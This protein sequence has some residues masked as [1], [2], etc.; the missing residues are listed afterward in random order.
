MAQAL[1]RRGN[2]VTILT[3]DALDQSQRY[4][5]SADEIMDGVRVVRVR[6]LSPWL[7]GQAN[8]STPLGMRKIAPELLKTVDIIHCHEFRTLENLLVTPFAASLNKPLILSPHGT[9][10]HETGR[11]TLK[12]LWDRLLSPTV[13]RRFSD[14]VGLSAIEVNEVRSLWSSFGA[15]ANFTV[16]PNGVDPQIFANLPGR[17][18]F[19]QRYRL[20]D[21]P[22]CLFMGRLHERKGI[23]LLVEAFKAAD[24]AEAKLVI[25]GPDEGMLATIQPLLDDRIIYTGYLSGSERLA[26]FAAADI[27][28][29][30][31]IGE[32]LPM[33]VLEAMAAGLPVIVS[34]GCNLPEVV[35]YGAGIEANAAHEPLR[36][37][38]RQLLSDADKRTKMGTAAKALVAERFTWDTIAEQ[39]ERVYHTAT[40]SA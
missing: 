3:T 7:R 20:G 23:G 4:H 33:V 1:T 15:Q 8:L 40:P 6:N 14:V 13:A 29:L 5:E 11:G 25:V 30:P 36:D 10:T 17:T 24:I 16:I 21:G 34:P 9:L 19:R 31:A 27:L 37:A 32:G 38:L 22:V 18:A 28:A 12:V 39:L 26:A 2:T 35:Q